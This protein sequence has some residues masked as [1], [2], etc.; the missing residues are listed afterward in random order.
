MN[1]RIIASVSL[2][3]VAAVGTTTAAA[4]PQGEQLV[5]AGSTLVAPIMSS[6]A[7]DW[8]KSSG[9]SVTYGPIGSGGGIAQVT[10]RTVDFGASDAPMTADQASKA[11][12]VLQVPWALAATLVA[13]NVSGVK[14]IHLSGLVLSRMYLGK[15]KFWDD[16]AVK[17]L[18]KKLKLPHLPVTPVYRSDGSGDTYVFTD[19]LSQT[20]PSWRS[21][22][23][24]ATQVSFPTGVGGKGND[25]VAAVVQK[26]KGAL[27]Y[28]AI[29]YVLQNKMTYALIRNAANR[30]V[31]PNVASI[32]A[33][34]ATV[35]N[36]PSSNAIS[37]VNPPASAPTAYPMSTFTYALVPHHSPKAALLKQFL[38]YA[39]TTGQKFGPKLAFAPL[40]KRILTID[41]T[42]ISRITT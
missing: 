30:Y 36:V 26:T 29:S 22:V 1:M 33:A 7:D 34:A 4:R 19:F 35:G 42:T 24:N 20:S 3:A 10:A 8:G 15:I 12:D 2:V 6:W 38:N 9:N 27:G 25:G 28:I 11:N 23:G 17:A 13:Y 37:I 31:T 41:K 18:N 16:P 5:G 21:N 40:P 14:D 39:I 32:S